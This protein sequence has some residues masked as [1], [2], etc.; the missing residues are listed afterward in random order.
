MSDESSTLEVYT[1]AFP[2]GGQKHRVSTG[3]G[4]HPS[5]RGDSRELFYLAPDRKLMAAD[6]D[7]DTLR[8]EPPRPLF[9]TRIMGVA[10]NHYTVTA[11]GQRF[12]IN[13]PVSDT[14]ISPI[15]VILN[16]AALLH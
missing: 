14:A 5:W 4:M 3:G 6:I 10:R 2:T 12:L 9:Q 11:D 15:T 13:S 8:A 1:I 7:P 16:S